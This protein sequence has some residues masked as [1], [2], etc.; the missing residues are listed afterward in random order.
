MADE[1]LPSFTEFYA[2]LGGA[3]STWASVEIALSQLFMR[4]LDSP[5]PS[6]AFAA[7]DAIINFRDK[8]AV[9]DA[10]IRAASMN[11]GDPALAEWEKLHKKVSRLSRR[12]NY[13]AH[14]QAVAVPDYE[15]RKTTVYAMPRSLSGIKDVKM[16]RDARQLLTLQRAFHLLYRRIIEFHEKVEPKL[17][18]KPDYAALLRD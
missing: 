11:P 8:L 18:Q 2:A 3:I 16:F 9:T 5:W 14:A 7:F 15:A 10:A 1:P 4:A 6:R 12:R 17:R 13:I